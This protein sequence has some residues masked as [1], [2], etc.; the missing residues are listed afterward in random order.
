MKIYPGHFDRLSATCSEVMVA[1][2]I[3]PRQIK[4]ERQRW[5]LFHLACERNRGLLDTLYEYLNDDHID[6]ALRKIVSG[7]P[8]GHRPT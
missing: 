5:V 8:L 3:Y 4:T 2:F 6:T 1:H 7:K